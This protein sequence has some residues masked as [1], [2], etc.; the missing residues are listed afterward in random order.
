MP[1]YDNP[2]I[3]ATAIDTK[4]DYCPRPEDRAFRLALE[5]GAKRFYLSEERRL[6]KTSF[7]KMA[8]LESKNLL[9][10]YHDLGPVT[11]FSG[12]LQLMVTLDKAIAV[13]P[14]LQQ[15]I[16][17]LRQN[18]LRIEP[19]TEEEKHEFLGE[20]INTLAVC[21]TSKKK[22]VLILDEFQNIKNFDESVRKSLRDHLQHAPQL[23]VIYCGSDRTKLDSLFNDSHEVFWKQADKFKL[24]PIPEETFFKFI[25]ERLHKRKRPLQR[26]TFSFIYQFCLGNSGDIQHLMSRLFERTRTSEGHDITLLMTHHEIERKTDELASEFALK[27]D[28]LTQDQ[29]G[30]LNSIAKARKKL[31]SKMMTTSFNQEN[32]KQ[33]RTEFLEKTIGLLI[34]KDIIAEFHSNGDI[35]FCS[36]Y[37][38]TWLRKFLGVMDSPPP[39]LDRARKGDGRP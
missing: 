35:K 26:E 15:R 9:G 2:F 8:I 18:L 38:R 32:D 12:L 13:P 36:P 25:Q 14:I 3:F 23:T 6:G 10:F 7:I 27:Y 39:E 31:T 1:T 5:Q 33:R 29:K 16:S 21:K 19:K 24:N 20:I 22:P 28:H 17:D 34:K 4:E 11:S 37:F 30:V